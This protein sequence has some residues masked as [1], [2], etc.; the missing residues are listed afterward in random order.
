[1]C[2]IIGVVDFRNTISVE[3]VVVARDLMLRRGPDDFGLE[4]Y[5]F[6]NCK[7]HL[8]HRRLSI[9]DLSVAARQPF[10]SQDKKWSIVFNGEIYNFRELREELRNLGHSF[11]TN[12]D[13]EVIIN[14]F[15]EWGVHSI[16]KFIGMFSLAILNALDNKLFLVR[17]RSGVKPLYYHHT[18]GKLIFC[19]DQKSILKLLG[20]EAS[21]NLA[22]IP[23]HMRY[24]Y[25]NSNRSFVKEINKMEPGTLISFCLNTNTFEQ[26]KYWDPISFFLK[27]KNI[28]SS[29]N[30]YIEE[31]EPILKSAFSY[32]M[33]ADV[34]VGVFLSG[35]YDSS[36]LCALL[37]H[38]GH[39]FKSFSISFEDKAYDEGPFAKRVSEYLEIPHTQYKC[40]ASDAKALILE[41][42]NINDEPLG[43]ISSIPTTLVSRLASHEV[44]VVLSADGAD[45]I[46]GGYIKYG[47]S[48]KFSKKLKMFPIQGRK[49]LS[50]VSTKNLE[51]LGSMLLGRKLGHSRIEKLK[52]ALL[53]Q[54]ATQFCDELATEFV[55]PFFNP[56]FVNETSL[57][58][59]EDDIRANLFQIDDLIDQMLAFDYINYLE[60][61]ILKKVDRATMFNSIEGREPFLDHRIFEFM[62]SVPSNL[63]INQQLQSK[64]LLKQITHKYLPKNMMDRP[65]MGFEIPIHNW[66]HEKGEL[67][68]V[69]FDAISNQH[70]SEFKIFD[71]TEIEKL[72]NQYLK[73]GVSSFQALWNLF[74][75]SHWYANSTLKGVSP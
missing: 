6:N 53:S 36:I 30:Q 40:T 59:F 73:D 52:R 46:F 63:K 31:L 39:D 4:S 9:I 7:V 67:R 42:I 8:G 57:S 26:I 75:F 74:T 2:G 43:D 45:E 33:V 70:L 15:E 18:E 51:S 61:D 13:T 14:A 65:K 21:L 10:V 47:R 48:V 11:N 19:S 58:F 62:A 12:S 69:F 54:S 41:L 5:S 55:H 3:E 56:E 23:F 44:K 27:P 24:G 72:K 17:D 1:M 25:L 64:V 22:N 28:Y 16:S 71:L 20:T 66:I 29:T 49:Y 60:G 50:R 35:G 38:Q 34:P 32:R 68:D 37:K